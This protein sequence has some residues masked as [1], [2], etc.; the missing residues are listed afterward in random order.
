MTGITTLNRQ[1]SSIISAVIEFSETRT[2][3][4]DLYT[5][6]YLQ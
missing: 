6:K 2:S 5:Y 3:V 4:R 1:T